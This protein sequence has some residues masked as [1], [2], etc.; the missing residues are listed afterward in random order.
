MVFRWL[1]IKRLRRAREAAQ[2]AYRAAI[3]RGDTRAMN[4]TL[5]RLRAA[6]H[7]LMEGGG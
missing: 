7:Q 1:R 6:T 5:R 3:E 4:A 2:Q